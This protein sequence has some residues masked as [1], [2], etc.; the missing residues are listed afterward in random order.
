MKVWPGFFQY[1]DSSD[2]LVQGKG[3]V[4]TYWLLGEDSKEDEDLADQ[5][6]DAG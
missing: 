4:T 3:M 1:A 5:E 6:D 2:N